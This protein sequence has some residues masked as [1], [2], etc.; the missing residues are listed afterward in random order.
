MKRIL[1]YILIFATVSCKSQE[2][3]GQYFKLPISPAVDTTKLENQEILSIA[4]NF[5]KT[6]N[7]SLFKNKYWLESDFEKYQYPYADIYRIENGNHGVNTYK[8]IL[9]ELVDIDDQEKMLKIGFIGYNEATEESLIRG[10]YNIVAIKVNNNSWYLKR[11]IDYQTKN[12]A[13]HKE[14]SLTYILPQGKTANHNEILQQKEDIKS[15]CSFFGCDPIE[16]TYYSC[17]SPKQVFEVKG[18]DYLPNMY[19]SKTG[20][21]ADYGNIIYS[22]NNSEYYTHEIVHIYTKKLF[23]NIKAILDEGIAT[24]IGGSGKFNYQWHRDKMANY[25]MD[26]TIN[27]AE[28][29]KPYERL[30]VEA[31]TP[32]PYLIG[33]LICERT[34]RI[35][36]KQKLFEL[37]NSEK[38]I[39]E[40]LNDVGLTRQNLTSE[41]KNEI[42][43]TTTLYMKS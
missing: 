12:W 28:H 6:K 41:L 30:Y 37:L 22:G 10:I 19:F 3:E 42:K 27:L 4:K 24:Y 32:I 36:G 21:M 34:N 16:I 13:V 17:N 33:A 11:A 8:P 25:L 38:N 9:M 31:E 20:G 39:W 18:F 15:I 7:Q 14:S 35:Y 40:S 2:Q 23:P 1:L 26:S 43:L 5:L 29:L